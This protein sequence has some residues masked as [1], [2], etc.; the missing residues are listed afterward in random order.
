[1]FLPHASNLAVQTRLIQSAGWMC[2]VAITVL[3]LIPGEVRPS[4]GTPGQMEHVAAY[5]GASF[6][7]Y[8][9]YKCPLLAALALT[10]YAGCLE[11]AQNFVPG[12]HPQLID[13]FA[14]GAGAAVG[15]VAAWLCAVGCT[16]RGLR[17]TIGGK[18][19]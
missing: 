16:A 3:S 19:T 9:G 15:S 11:I 7:L 5:A 13:W 6:V 8:F 1:L 12:R 2:I 14:G 17:A 18:A 4:T 10:G